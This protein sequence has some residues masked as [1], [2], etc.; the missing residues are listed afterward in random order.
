MTSQAAFSRPMTDAR[1]VSA[2]RRLLAERFRAAGIET[3]EF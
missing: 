2:A 3:P 1:T